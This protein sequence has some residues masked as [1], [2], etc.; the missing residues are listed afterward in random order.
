MGVSTLTLKESTKSECKKSEEADR[1]NRRFHPWTHERQ[2][3]VYEIQLIRGYS[4]PMEGIDRIGGG[5]W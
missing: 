2:Q 1:R 3:C 5:N 4:H